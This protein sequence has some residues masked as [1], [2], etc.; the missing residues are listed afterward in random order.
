MKDPENSSRDLQRF[1]P[2]PLKHPNQWYPYKKEA[3]EEELF[4]LLWRKHFHKPYITNGQVWCEQYWEINRFISGY[5]YFIFECY[6]V[7]FDFDRAYD[8]RLDPDKDRDLAKQK[9]SKIIWEIT[10]NPHP[11][12]VELLTY[13]WNNQKNPRVMIDLFFREMQP[14]ID[15][16]KIRVPYNG[17]RR[18]SLKKSSNTN[19]PPSS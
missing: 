8:I 7:D 12:L 13:I 14:L 1:V 4:A 19:N 5:H 9:Y 18:I 3:L 2:T 11:K 16:I 10:N 15:Q 6:E 17:E